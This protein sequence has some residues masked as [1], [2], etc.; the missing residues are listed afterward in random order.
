M[1]KDKEIPVPVTYGD[2]LL[3]YQMGYEVIFR[4]GAVYKVQHRKDKEKK[5]K[6]SK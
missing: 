3:L 1:K 5:I 6:L 2:C 4:N